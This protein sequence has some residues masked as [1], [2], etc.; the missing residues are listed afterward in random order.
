VLKEKRLTLLAG[1][2]SSVNNINGT[3]NG[4]DKTEQQDASGTD[5]DVGAERDV[6]RASESNWPFVGANGET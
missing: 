2:N 1:A 5:K 6:P 3:S 4:K